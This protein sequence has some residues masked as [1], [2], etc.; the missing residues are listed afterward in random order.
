MKKNLYFIL[1]YNKGISPITFKPITTFARYFSN[2]PLKPRMDTVNNINNF[3][4]IYFPYLKFASPDGLN[5]F[6]SE[7]LKYFRLNTT[8]SII[9]KIE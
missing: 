4:Y 2:L 8:Y 7:I 6:K 5:F 9:L 3:N 1:I